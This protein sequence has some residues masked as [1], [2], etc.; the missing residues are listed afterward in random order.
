MQIETIDRIEVLPLGELFLGLESGGGNA[1]YQYVYR[2]AAGVYWDP[3][4]KGFRS[5]VI[6]EW[7]VPQWFAHIVETV[8]YTGITLILRK[9]IVWGNI[10][11]NDKTLVRAWMEK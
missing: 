8:Q 7:T 1:S 6:R 5:T 11:H 10:S 3:E 4:R 9:D 2:E